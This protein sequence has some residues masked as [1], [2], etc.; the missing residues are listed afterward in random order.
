MSGF[1]GQW[2]RGVGITSAVLGISLTL[3]SLSAISVLG[4]RAGYLVMLAALLVSNMMAWRHASK[5]ARASLMPLW[6]V[7]MG[8]L[9]VGGAYSV[10]VLGA[11]S[12]DEQYAGFDLFAFA[13]VMAVI[14]L[15][16][17]AL[18]CNSIDAHRIINWSAISYV[19]ILAPCVVLFFVMGPVPL[20][21]AS[22]VYF[23]PLATNLHHT[24]LAALTQLVLGVIALSFMGRK[25]SRPWLALAMIVAVAVG[26]LTSSSKFTLSLLM[27]AGMFVSLLMFWMAKRRALTRLPALTVAGASFALITLAVPVLYLS[28]VDFI[29]ALGALFTENDQIGGRQVIYWTA[30]PRFIESPMFGYG[31]GAQVWAGGYWRDAHSSL[32][33]MVLQTGLAGTL[34]V[35]LLGWRWFRSLPANMPVVIVLSVFAVYGIFGDLH[36]NVGFWVALVLATQM[37]IRLETGGASSRVPRNQY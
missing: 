27:W 32:L 7:Y 30:W 35:M 22:G 11:D 4:M 37:S 21:S 3:S 29:S 15:S 28:G 18:S 9:L 8:F 26:L 1:S 10:L 12:L 24:A 16:E 31:P 5:S 33:S 6:W 20:M 14:Y 34:A 23:S 36:R 2:G 19:V 17:R 25:I 13:V